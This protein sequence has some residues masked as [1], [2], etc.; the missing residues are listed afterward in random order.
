MLAGLLGPDWGQLHVAH[1]GVW[2]HL[3]PLWQLLVAR[4][5]HVQHVGQRAQLEVVTVWRGKCQSISPSLNQSVHHR[6]K[7]SITQTLHARCRQRAH[8]KAVM[9]WRQKHQ[10]ISPSIRHKMQSPSLNCPAGSRRGLEM[11]TSINQSIAQPINQTQYARHRQR[12]QLEVD[13][14]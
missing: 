10:S 13:V 6:I 1:R 14:V 7:Q 2:S 8:S 12:A 3:R 5:P 9:V 11:G 4:G